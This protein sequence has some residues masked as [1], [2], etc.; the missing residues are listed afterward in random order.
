MGG[1]IFKHRRTPDLLDGGG[2]GSVDPNNGTSL[3]GLWGRRQFWQIRARWV[4]APLMIVGILVGRALGFEFRALPILLIALASLL[5]NSLFAWIFTRYASRLEEDPRLDRLFTMLEVLADYAAMFVL[6]YF[7]GGVA[8]PMVVFLIFHVIIAAIQFSPREAYQLA[9][10]AALGLWLM[11]LA[12]ITGW[13]PC[14]EFFYRGQSL[15][16]LHQTAYASIALLF[17]TA[18]LYLTVAM[19]NRVMNR[20]RSRAR[21]LAEMTRERT[22]FMLQVAHNLRAPL[23]AALSMLELVRDGYVGEV[24]ERQTDYLKRIEARLA[25]LNQ[26]IGELLT[27]ARTRD[28]TREIP[29][30]V[31]DLEQLARHVER[32]FRQEAVNRKLR[33]RVVTDNDLPKVDSGTNLLEQVMENLVSNA[34]KYTPEGG[35]VEVR[36]SRHGLDE[37]EIEVRDSGIGI[38]ESEQDKLFQEFFRA[39]NAKRLTSNGTGLGL[40][41]VKQTVERHNG[42]MKVTSSEG[43]GTSVVI[44]LPIHQ[45]GGQREVVLS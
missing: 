13:L 37:V 14:D 22:R 42:T 44:R 43:E 19:V 21:A 39:S 24:S 15:H 36:L 31:I 2:V 6:I 7:T 10:L 8:S 38:P 40:A 41:L 27:I 3:P 18:T 35:E 34:I 32:T 29:D 9:T 16:S 23:S 45:P 26:M 20:F 33:Y 25:S 5:Y 28:K 1:P 4:V 11:L 30:A 17:F 12:D